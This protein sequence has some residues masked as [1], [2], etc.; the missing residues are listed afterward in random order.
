M[1]NLIYTSIT[2]SSHMNTS[3]V[4][5]RNPTSISTPTGYSHSA[6][7]DLGTCIMLIVSGQV[8]VDKQGNLVGKG[9]LG[10]QAEQVFLN[11]KSIVEEAG[12]TMENVV[13]TGVY[14]VDLAQTQLFRDVRNKFINPQKPPTSTLV[15]VS[16]LFSDDW[17]IEI[18]ATAII[19]K[20]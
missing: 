6:E 16:K 17:L 19:P 13:R 7:I 11:I 14:M 3:I 10:K 5:F 8:P 20:K 15:Q 12:G 4:K 18:E 1:E 9:N 2:G